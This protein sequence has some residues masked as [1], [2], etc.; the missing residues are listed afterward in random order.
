MQ[1]VKA[2]ETSPT[3]IFINLVSFINLSRHQSEN[4]EVVTRMTVEQQIDVDAIHLKM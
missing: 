2:V 3:T 1:R 4:L